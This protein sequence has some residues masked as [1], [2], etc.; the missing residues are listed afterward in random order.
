ME[1]AK[2]VIFDLAKFQE[3]LA[4]CTTEKQMNFM[5]AQN[6]IPLNNI[7][8]NVDCKIIKVFR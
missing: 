4:C 5:I 8:T 7:I 1:Q 3:V 6:Q 2:I